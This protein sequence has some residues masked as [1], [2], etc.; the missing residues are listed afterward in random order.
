MCGRFTLTRPGDAVQTLFHLEPPSA[1]KARYNIAPTDPVWALRVCPGSD[2]PELVELRWGLVPFWAHDRKS[3]A[4]MI[5]ARAETAASKPA[6]REG[7]RERRCLIPADGFY[8]WVP[9]PKKTRQPY[10]I[11]LRE[12][13]P[14]CF[15]GIWASWRSP[16][17]ERLETCCI[18]TTDPNTLVKPVH[19]RMPVILSPER[20]ATWLDPQAQSEEVL[21]PLWAPFPAEAMETFPVSLRVNAVANDDPE[22]VRPVPMTQGNR[23]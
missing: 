11:R 6:F 20:Y 13:R 17:G 14:F 18:L 12:G 3:A 10:Y 7:L 9:G 8:E 22:C 1:M 16:E 21:R 2:G 5:N 4:R 15:A 19:D 23:T